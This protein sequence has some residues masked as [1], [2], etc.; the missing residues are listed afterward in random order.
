MSPRAAAGLP[1]AVLVDGRPGAEVSAIERGLHYG[2]GLFET[3]ACVGGEPRLLALHL[4]RLLEGCRRLALRPPETA[5]LTAEIAS[6]ARGNERAVL[7]LLV[8]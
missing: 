7:K 3:I 5:Q 2:D 1:E 4:T 8:T 6:L